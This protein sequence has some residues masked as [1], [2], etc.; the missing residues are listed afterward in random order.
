[1]NVEWYCVVVFDGFLLLYI[2]F[3]LGVV[4]W[5]DIVM[6]V[7]WWFFFV[8]DRLMSIIYVIQGGI[9]VVL[10]CEVFV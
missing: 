7:C 4:G 8:D 3:I 2:L 10:L 9:V 5:L 1:M 6:F